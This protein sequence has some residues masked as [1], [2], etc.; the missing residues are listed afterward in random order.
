MVMRVRIVETIAGDHERGG[1]GNKYTWMA[2][3]V[4]Q[5]VNAGVGS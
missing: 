2:E 1:G 5:V 4:V 3:L